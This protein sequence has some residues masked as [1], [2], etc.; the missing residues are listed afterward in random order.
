MGWE[1]NGITEIIKHI[2]KEGWRE[3]KRRRKKR[4]RGRDNEVAARACAL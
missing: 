3:T 4:Y 1:G 2:I